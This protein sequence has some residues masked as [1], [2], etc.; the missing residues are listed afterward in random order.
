MDRRLVWPLDTEMASRTERASTGS[1][2][3]PVRLKAHG[4]GGLKVAIQQVVL[5][6]GTTLLIK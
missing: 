4:L 5:L 3:E 2:T 6:R 1:P